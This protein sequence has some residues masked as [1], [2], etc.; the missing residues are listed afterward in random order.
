[1]QS[2]LFKWPWHCDNRIAFGLTELCRPLLPSNGNKAKKN[3]IAY[4]TKSYQRKKWN[5]PCIYFL[6][7]AGRYQI[8]PLLCYLLL[9]LWCS[10]HL[11]IFFMTPKKKKKGKKLQASHQKQILICVWSWYIFVE[12]LLLWVVPYKIWYA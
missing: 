7:C 12:L 4:T 3:P 1:M 10:Q 2:Y 5:L 9:S 8:M 6:P 11:F